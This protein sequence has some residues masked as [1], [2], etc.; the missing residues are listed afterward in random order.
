MIQA[1]NLSY[2][3]PQKDLYKKISFHIKQGEHAALIG[4]NGVG[5]STLAAMIREPE[6][7]LFEG[8][9][10]V[11]EPEPVG[12]VTQ[13][14]DK[15]A[16]SETVFSYISEEFVQ[17]QKKIDA[18][19]EELAQTEDMEA[20][21]ERYQK[22]LDDFTAIDGEHYESNIR[23][24]LKIAGLQALE[25]EPI[26]NLSGGEG[27]LV[28]VIREMLVHPRILVMDEPD[29]FLD[30]EHLNAL[31]RL[32][33]QHKGTLLV[34]THNRYL[35][36]YCFDKILNLEDGQLDEYEGSYPEYNL[37][38]LKRKIEQ[39]ELAQ[40]DE[41]EIQRNRQLVEKL[42][43]E[44]T[45][46]DNPTRGKTL[47]ARVSLLER[48]EARKTRQPFVDIKEPL[49]HLETAVPETEDALLTLENYNVK[50]GNT[51]FEDLQ[52]TLQ[53]HEKVAVVGPN[54]TGKT[55]LLREIFQN[56]NP[57]IRL[58]PQAKVS[59][60]S[61]NPDETILE[62]QTVYEALNKEEKLSEQQLNLILDDYG[63]LEEDGNRYVSQLSGGERNLLQLACI[64]ENTG[65]LLLLDEPSSHLDIYAQMAL[66]RALKEYNG[67]ILM[68]SHDFY[69]IANTMDYVLLIEECG[70]RKVSIRKFRK[71]MYAE[72]FDKD[73]LEREQ[74]RKELESKILS[75]LKKKD[76]HMAALLCEKL[77]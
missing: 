70:L 66:E 32:I 48:L 27:K 39:Q 11:T 75:A 53:P 8:K 52:L 30:F 51:L 1:I 29:G 17:R 15:D 58:S 55:T 63:F 46:F 33:N 45:M 38:L 13:F 74:K 19:C 14:F 64:A 42:R 3:F 44:A 21:L 40:A 50:F 18:L 57:A 22:A 69:M 59:Y 10:L 76:Y 72:Y 60:L 5:K 41:E 4:S 37:D 34:I 71:M 24:Q 2:S 61:Q 28:Q 56:N 67:G 54:G 9:L 12:Y 36:Q 62:Q 20:T 68:V 7:Y 73:Y 35:L 65:N 25:E 16:V 43:K 77:N 47:H 31:R 6:E 23:R 49:I 26:A